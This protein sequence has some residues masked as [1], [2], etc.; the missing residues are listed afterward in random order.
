[1]DITEYCDVLNLE[2]TILYYPNQGGRW[3]ADIKGAEI[4]E[5]ASSGILTSAHGNGP[6]PEEAIDDYVQQIRGKLLVLNASGANRLEYTVPMHIC[7][8]E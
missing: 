8:S 4:K 7:G 3:C 1:M 6:T 2:L 5:N